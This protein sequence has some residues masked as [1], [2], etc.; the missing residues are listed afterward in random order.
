MAI[1]IGP[2][3]SLASAAK[4]RGSQPTAGQQNAGQQAARRRTEQR[5]DRE[6]EDSRRGAE[7]RA[8]DAVPKASADVEDLGDFG[9]VEDDELTDDDDDD[10][11]LAPGDSEQ[12]PA[13]P[14][15]TGGEA[16]PSTPPPAETEDPLD[17]GGGLTD[18]DLGPADPQD[19]DDQGRR[20]PTT[21][22]A[23]TDEL[24]D[25]SR[26]AMNDAD[27]IAERDWLSDVAGRGERG[28][29]RTNAY[30]GP[31]RFQAETQYRIGGVSPDAYEAEF[32]TCNTARQERERQD[33]MA[34]QPEPR[35]D[36]ERG[37]LLGQMSMAEASWATGAE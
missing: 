8:R 7:D 15:R 28:E 2:D 19:D 1:R 10:F 3:R 11:G 26:R 16:R 22:K 33:W 29:L 37:F 20:A 32:A 36:A 5:R 23:S 30:I 12:A 24:L 25:L 13:S 27:T 18:A 17:E 6:T 31:A 9:D 21:R 34:T 4:P 35:F 14:S